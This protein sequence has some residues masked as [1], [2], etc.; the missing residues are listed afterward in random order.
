MVKKTN[1]NEIIQ[2]II[3]SQS[4]LNLHESKL[5]PSI[6]II[7]CA[8]SGNKPIPNECNRP[9][10]PVA[11]PLLFTN[12]LVTTVEA[13]ICIGELKIILPVANKI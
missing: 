8:K 1:G 12:H 11:L 9:N 13:P 4:Q 6:S 5:L 3:P 10:I 7:N 2:T